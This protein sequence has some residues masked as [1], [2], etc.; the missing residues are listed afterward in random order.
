[1][2][3]DAPGVIKIEFSKTT[4]GKD[5]FTMHVDRSKLRDVG[6]A[7]LDAF[8]HKLHVYK[9][10]GDFETA[11]KF[12][13]HYSEV[14]EEMLKV[15]EIVMANRVPRRLELQPNILRNCQG[16]QTYTETQGETATLEYKDYDQSFAGIV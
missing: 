14:D 16:T 5:W 10:L 1:M 13:Q 8:L 15:R 7:A 6:F 11:E 9:S 3:E 4:E 12:F 2:R